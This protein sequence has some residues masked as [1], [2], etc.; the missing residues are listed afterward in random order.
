MQEPHKDFYTALYKYL[1]YPVCFFYSIRINCMK[2]CS[3]IK[4]LFCKTFHLLNGV[5]WFSPLGDK[6]GSVLIK[7]QAGDVIR[8]T[9]SSFYTPIHCIVV[10][11]KSFG[12]FWLR[13][14]LH[15]LGSESLLNFTL[16]EGIMFFKVGHYSFL[17]VPWQTCLPYNTGL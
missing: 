8:I 3:D 1:C 10:N 9:L 12:K 17:T 11:I 15:Y 14:A 5:K 6:I 2:R 7:K 16:L 13:S 4:T